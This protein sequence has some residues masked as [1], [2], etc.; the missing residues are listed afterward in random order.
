MADKKI[1][2][3]TELTTPVNNDELA[4]VDKDVNETKKIQY[5]NL[6]DHAPK[7]HGNEAHSSSFITGAEVPANETDPNVDATLKAITLTEVRDHDPKA[8]KTSHQDAGSDEI[9]LT[10]LTGKGYTLHVQALTSSPA[11]SVSRYFGNLPKAPVSSGAI[12]KVYIR[13]AGTIKIAEIYCYSG[14]AGTNEAWSLYVRL[15]NTTDYLIATLSAATNERVFSNTGLSIP[16]VAGDYIEIKMVNP[17][18]ATN[19]LTTIFG[20]YLYIE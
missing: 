15:N 11:D 5:S 4:I 17:L 18:W 8:H 13:K 14:T 12:S 1:S 16:V 20:G 2:E 9:D 10:G 7:S 6:K 3:L 19:P